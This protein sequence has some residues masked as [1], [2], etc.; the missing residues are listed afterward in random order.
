VAYISVFSTGMGLAA[1]ADATRAAAVRAWMAFLASA[2]VEP[3]KRR[4]GMHWI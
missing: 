1:S 3:I 4:H 2:E